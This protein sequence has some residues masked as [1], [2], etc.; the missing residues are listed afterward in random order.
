MNHSEILFPTG[1]V[2]KEVF[3]LIILFLHE[4]DSIFILMDHV[5]ELVFDLIGPLNLLVY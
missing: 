4:S 5:I 1:P 3:E 2:I